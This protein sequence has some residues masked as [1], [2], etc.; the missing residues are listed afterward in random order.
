M[1][2]VGRTRNRPEVQFTLPMRALKIKDIRA[3]VTN[4][5]VEV[6][7][8]KV[9]VQGTIAKQVFFVG[10]DDIVHHFP[11]EMR[12][13]ALVEVPGARPGM[14]VQVHPSIFNVIA[15]LSPDGNQI[16]QKVIVDVGVVVTDFVQIH[17]T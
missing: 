17:V 15:F 8:D 6:I 11:E 4:V 14:L 7:P 10:E 5:S 16:L 2:T 9:I 13:S 12:F 1:A 3:D